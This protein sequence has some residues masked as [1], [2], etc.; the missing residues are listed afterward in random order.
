LPDRAVGRLGGTYQ[1]VAN[2]LV[3]GHQFLFVKSEFCSEPGKANSFLMMAWFRITMSNPGIDVAPGEL[4][5][6][7]ACATSITHLLSNPLLY[8]NTVDCVSRQKNFYVWLK[9]K[10]QLL[11]LSFQSR[12]RRPKTNH[13]I[14]SRA[15]SSCLS[16]ITKQDKDMRIWRVAG[17]VLAAGLV[18]FLLSLLVKMLL[19]G[20]AIF[21][22]VRV[23]GARLMGRSFGPLG[24]GNWSSATIISIDNPTYR[25]PVNQAG[26][27]RIIPIG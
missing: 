20:A 11:R 8:H 3:P 19:I 10:Y 14:L 4:Y 1:P 26:F 6:R 9:Y 18:L 5:L 7:K 13:L 23:V 12:K 27:G 16:Q 17:V 21:L 2:V 15:L 24:Q 22:L 25:S